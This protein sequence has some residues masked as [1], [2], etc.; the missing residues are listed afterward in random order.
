MCNAK[1]TATNSQSV[2][3][4]LVNVGYADWL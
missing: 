2:H 1:V 4:L 3:L